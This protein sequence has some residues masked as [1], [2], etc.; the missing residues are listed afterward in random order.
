MSDTLRALAPPAG[1][2]LHGVYTGG[3]NGEEDDFRPSDLDA[4]IR[5]VGAKPAGPPPRHGL[6]R[7]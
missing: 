4:Y 6:T 3:R 2:L 7:R 5:T 1:K